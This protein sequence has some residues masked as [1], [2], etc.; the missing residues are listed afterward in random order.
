[1]QDQ[2]SFLFRRELLKRGLALGGVALVA[3]CQSSPRAESAATLPGPVW[4]DEAYVGGSTQPNVPPPAP[5][6]STPQPTNRPVGVIPR[7]AWAK[8]QPRWNLTKPMNGVSRIT[9]H[10]EGDAVYTARTQS[11]VA[12]RLEG[13]RQYHRSKGKEWADIGYHYII[14]PA[15]RVWEG[16]PISVEG[17]HVAKTN[18]HNLGVMVLGNFDRQSPTGDQLSSLVGFVRSQ[19]LR[20]RVPTSRLYT[21]QELRPTACPGRNLQSFMNSVRNRGGSLVLG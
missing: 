16:R 7:S 13:I 14:D 21:H 5:G 18:D 17:A 9:V 8:D 4:P 11:T 19:M 1:M 15:G 20:Y 6:V 10:H 12:R 3:G 2:E